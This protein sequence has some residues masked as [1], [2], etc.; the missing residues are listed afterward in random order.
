MAKHGREIKKL[1]Q[2]RS[3]EAYAEATE[4]C[5]WFVMFMPHKIAVAVCGMPNSGAEPLVRHRCA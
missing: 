3:F 5:V 2:L 4:L 1:L